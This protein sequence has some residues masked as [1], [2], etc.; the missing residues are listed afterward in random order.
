MKKT[1]LRFALL[2]LL[3]MLLTTV[4]SAKAEAATLSQSNTVMGA[5]DGF[6]FGD[7]NLDGAVTNA[8]ALALFRYIYDPAQYPLPVLCN[9]TF[10][11]WTVVEEPDCITDGLQMRTCSKCGG[12]EEN[13]TKAPGKHAEVIDA[14]VPATC[15]ETGLTEGKHCSACGKVLVE[16]E[17]VPAAHTPGEWVIT[18]QPTC[19]TVGSKQQACTVCGSTIK[20]EPIPTAAHN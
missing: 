17:V 10:G 18:T 11:E 14:A 20:T 6:V 19:T 16:Q 5:E 2:V 15:T 1:L 13:V 9:H 4:C 3:C 7:V 8:D 12:V